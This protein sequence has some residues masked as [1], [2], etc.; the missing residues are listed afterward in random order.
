MTSEALPFEVKPL[1]KYNV[2]CPECGPYRDKRNTKTLTVYRDKDGF[3]R[4]QCSHVGQ[5][6]LNERKW[7]KDPNPEE[8]QDLPEMTSATIV[9]HVITEIPETHNGNQLWWYKDDDGYPLYAVM[10]KNNDTGKTYHPVSIQ[11]DGSTVQL[12]NWPAI[13]RLYGQENLK[14]N[15]KVLVVEGEKARDAAQRIFPE[16][17]VITWRGGA[18][19]IQ[20]ADWNA[21]E[22]K[23]V[24]LWPDNDEPGHKAMEKIASLLLRSTV[25]LVN[26]S[27]FP[28]KSDLADDLDLVK[29]K[30]LIKSAP[31]I[32]KPTLDI[33]SMES[34]EEQAEKLN[35]RF[36]IGWPEID[37]VVSFPAS[38]VVVLEGRTGHAKTGSAINISTNYLKSGGE[39]R[40][41]S[42]EIPASRV[43]TRFV[44]S[45]NADVEYDKVFNGDESNIV[46]GWID[47]QNLKIYD[48]S[49]QLPLK[50][51][52]ELL[53]DPS[54]S[55]SLV[56]IDYAQIV[57]CSGIEQ[58][59]KMIDL[60]DSLRIL[61]NT[62]GFL[63]LLLSQLT[64]DYANP[65]YDAPRDAKDIHFSAEMVLRVW[66]KDNEFGHPSY[67]EVPGNYTMHVYKNRDGES[68]HLIGF[69]WY[70]GAYLEPNGHIIK[71]GR[72][73]REDNKSAQA[74]EKIANILANQFGG[75]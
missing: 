54:L 55:R 17:A 36:S 40:F 50:R 10:R 8:V 33:C 14:E 41:F 34:I 21:L 20:S 11:E 19:N 68:G 45:L 23:T 71:A 75:V 60:M 22:G 70:K 9:R 56:V 73:K 25:H 67:D 16:V 32:H 63:V 59:T 74:L 65:L 26:V 4:W 44:R 37:E 24:W 57:P 5:C 51:L 7:A 46:R 69:A 29:V 53:D 31:V 49:K 61:A 35:K 72:V 6:T 52:K 13:S 38:G 43:F 1:R 64:P 30:E 18:A 27:S 62:H 12:P 28:R 3:I 66:N 15:N 39:V 42:Y 2:F 58:R 47:G 48:Q